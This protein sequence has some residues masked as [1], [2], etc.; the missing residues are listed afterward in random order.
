MLCG[1][2]NLPAL[3]VLDLSPRPDFASSLAVSSSSVSEPERE[4]SG[5]LTGDGSLKSERQLSF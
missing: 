2:S 5:L 1:G 3:H 4:H